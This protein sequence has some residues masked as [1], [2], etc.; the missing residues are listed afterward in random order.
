MKEFELDKIEPIRPQTDKPSIE[1]LMTGDYITGLSENSVAEQNVETEGGEYLQFPEGETQKI[2]G[3]SH[4]KGGVPM[5]LPDGTKVLSKTLKLTKEQA[6]WLNKTYDLNVTTKMSYAQALDK[7]AS[8][9]GLNKISA[10]QEDIYK[11]LKKQMD[12]EDEMSEGTTRINRNYIGEKIAKLESAKQ[13]LDKKKSEVFNRL[14]DMQ[15]STKEEPST[16]TVMRDG[17]ITTF[18]MTEVAKKLGISA[19]DVAKLMNE[20]VPRY[21]DGGQKLGI[22]TR[23]NRF[24][25]PN[26][27]TRTQQSPNESTYGVDKK[28][29]EILQELYYNFPDIIADESVFGKYVDIDKLINGDPEPFK[30]SLPFNKKLEAVAEFQKKADKRMKDSAKDVINNRELFTEDAVK[31]AQTYLNT[32]TFIENPKDKAEEVRSYDQKM[33][34][35]TSG[36]Y[37]LGV[38]SVTPEE[39]QKLRTMGVTTLNQLVNNPDAYNSLSE[40][41]KANIELLKGIKAK[42]S[43]SD[44][45]LDT[46]IPGPA[47]KQEEVPEEPYVNPDPTAGLVDDINLSGQRNSGNRAFYMPDQ[48]SLPPSPLEVGSMNE[49]QFQRIDP[50]KIGIDQAL[51]ENQNQMSAVSEML[52]DLPSNQKASALASILASSNEGINKSIVSANQINAQNQAAAEQFNIGQSDR[53]NIAKGQ[54][55]LNYEQRAMTAKSKTEEEIRRWFDRNQAV[56]LNNFSETQRLNLVDQLTPDYELNFMGTGVDYN[57]SYEWRVT[58]NSYPPQTTT[59]NAKTQIAPNGMTKEQADY[60][61][62]QVLQNMYRNQNK[63]K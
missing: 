63:G 53:E 52:A 47:K 54:N 22:S 44:Y 13:P 45:F 62:A 1:K 15:E 37:A 48:S 57:P 9:I 59:E 56:A 3:D 19:M 38:Q 55:L 23:T 20:A 6:K 40:Y 14:F 32:E 10:E 21:Q 28:P 34:N 11:T 5:N 7:Y 36:R 29:E 24:S 16:D 41:S 60:I 39:K 43:D 46:Y 61:A 31:A 17:G 50:V 27:Y 49:N 26:V 4:K 51:Q 35:F 8:K 58:N 33:G 12:L 25:D 42:D 18:K 2:I 30:S